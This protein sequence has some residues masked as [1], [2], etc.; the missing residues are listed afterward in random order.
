MFVRFQELDLST[1]AYILVDN[2][3]E[4]E[5]SRG[6]EFAIKGKYVKVC[7]VFPF[8]LCCSGRDH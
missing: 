5:W 2:A 6:I 1:E 8:L 4:E 7:A 3:K